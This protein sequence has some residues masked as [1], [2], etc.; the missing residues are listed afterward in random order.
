[1]VDMLQLHIPARLLIPKHASR[2]KSR[3][4]PLAWRLGNAPPHKF[5]RLC[6]RGR[7][8]FCSWESSPLSPA[9]ASYPG[10][11]VCF[12]QS[13]LVCSSQFLEK[14]KNIFSTCP[15]Q[16]EIPWL[17]NPLI[18]WILPRLSRY[19]RKSTQSGTELTS[20]LSLTPRRMEA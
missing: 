20:R 17:L 3:E 2:T 16:T 7:T 5:F 9:N 11:T 18:L 8:F 1:M 14:L 15:S 6:R 4:Q 19:L 12:V 10:T 13:T